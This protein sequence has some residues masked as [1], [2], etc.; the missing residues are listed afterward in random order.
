MSDTWRGQ[1][2]SSIESV[3]V[4]AH[5]R[6]R[7]IFTMRGQPLDTTDDEGKK[8]W[9]L[10]VVR[11]LLV[12]TR[13]RNYDYNLVSCS[14][15]LPQSLDFPSNFWVSSQKTLLQDLDFRH[16][17]WV[18]RK[19]VNPVI[20]SPGNLAVLY[21]FLTFLRLAHEVR[22]KGQTGKMYVFIIFLGGR[23]LGVEIY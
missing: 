1:M 23:A 18:S 19:S 16:D 9:T 5:C 8:C 11:V 13:A 12:V 2:Y 17:L 4:S 10:M 15:N 22:F 7:R 14:G 21:R 20:L 3:C 6:L